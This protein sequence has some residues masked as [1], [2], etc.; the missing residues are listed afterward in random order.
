MPKQINELKFTYSDDEIRVLL[1]HVRIMQFTVTSQIVSRW[2]VDP[3]YIQ[4]IRGTA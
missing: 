4:A 1:C 2:F 3:I